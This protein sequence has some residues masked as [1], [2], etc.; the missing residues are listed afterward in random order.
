MS[1]S[2]AE[3]IEGAVDSVEVISRSGC[4][5][6]PTREIDKAFHRLRGCLSPVLDPLRARALLRPSREWSDALRI[7][8]QRDL[9]AAMELSSAHPGAA[10]VLLQMS[11]EKLAKSSMAR[12]NEKL[13]RAHRMSHAVVRRFVPSL[14]RARIG[15]KWNKALEL[16]LQ[17]TNA[18]PALAKGGPHLEYPWDSERAVFL[19]DDNLEVVR[20]LFRGKSPQAGYLFNFL[21]FLLADFDRLFG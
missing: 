3:K 13:F 2:E 11:L 19:P 10:T 16:A 1:K 18:H 15:L 5:R 14:K 9:E 6:P 8:A 12:N 21:H 17:V 7:Q 4:P 20:V